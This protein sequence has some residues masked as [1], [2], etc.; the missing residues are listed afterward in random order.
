[1]HGC[2]GCGPVQD[3][4]ARAACAAG[5]AAVIVDSLGPRGLGGS[6]AALTVCSGLRLRGAERADDLRLVLAW[7]RDQPWADADR[8]AAA[9]WSH[10]GW[11]VMDGLAAGGLG[12]LKLAALFYPYAGVLSR[13]AARGWGEARPAVFACLAGRDRVVGSAGPRRALARLEADGVPVQHL[14]L[15]DATHAFDDPGAVDPRFHYRLDLAEQAR[16]A[17]VAILRQTLFDV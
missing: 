17:Y 13:T 7:I 2:A 8:L 1:M 5:V 16:A 6:E 12:Q 11:S 15:P 3:I 10:G 9:G 4:Y 14:E